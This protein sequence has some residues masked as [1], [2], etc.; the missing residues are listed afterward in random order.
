MRVDDS[1]SSARPHTIGVI[2]LN[3]RVDDSPSHAAGGFRRQ[4]AYSAR[5]AGH[6]EAISAQYSAMLKSPPPNA[7][8]EQTQQA[9]AATQM[10]QRTGA[11]LPL[12][13]PNTPP[14]PPTAPPLP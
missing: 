12:P 11:D 1:L 14:L 6:L 9:M 7:P 2:E 3:A 13:K 4:A 5:Y 8:Q 10:Y